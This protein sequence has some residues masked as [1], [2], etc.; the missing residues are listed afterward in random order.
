MLTHDEAYIL[1]LHIALSKEFRKKTAER[2]GKKNLF[3]KVTFLVESLVWEVLRD[4]H[5]STD[6]E[7][8]SATVVKSELRARNRTSEAAETIKAAE[9][10]IDTVFNL[11]ESELVPE[12]ADTYLSAALTATMKAEMVQS[13]Q[14]LHT[15]ED[16][17]RFINTAGKEINALSTTKI[18][19]GSLIQP[20][21]DPVGM[22]PA[23]QK[24]RT[25][26]MWFD[27]LSG[28]GHTLGECIGIL[29]PTGGGKTTTCVQILS[30]QAKMK[31]HVLLCTYEQTVKGDV[32]ERLFTHML[33]REVDYFRG[34][35]FHEWD[36]STQETFYKKR[37]IYG[38]YVHAIDFSGDIKSGVR[39]LDD[40]EDA[41]NDMDKA[42][43]TNCKYVLIDWLWPMVKRYMTAN[44]KAIGGRSEQDVATEMM[45]GFT[46]L[47]KKTKKIIVVFHQL[48][49]DAIS[50]SP[51]RIPITTDAYNF[52]TFAFYLDCCYLLGTRDKESDV[53]WSTVDKNRRN[54]LK[55]LLVK[56]NGA[57][58]RIEEAKNFMRDHRGRIVNKDEQIPEGVLKNE[59][60][61]K[62]DTPYHFG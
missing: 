53:M 52:R 6:A 32:S 27:S 22:L 19:A 4:M 60:T 30:A 50:S 25:G 38:P 13:I 20:L 40:V 1:L 17:D 56:L 9:D 47:A 61:G 31:Q 46:A 11:T 55:S 45:M 8:L 16:M 24:E 49:T 34:K 43:F 36:T 33:D 15:P 12:I 5:N 28:G 48:G 37:D 23:L 29:G 51:S 35:Q 3:N 57:W 41:I 14:A 21:L 39:G 62:P 26:V 7:R 59:Y 42:G 44:S 54:G 10:L 2:V 18:D 58:C